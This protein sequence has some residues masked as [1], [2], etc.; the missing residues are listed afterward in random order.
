MGR[1]GNG[2]SRVL[3]EAERRWQQSLFHLP[4]PHLSFPTIYPSTSIHYDISI[5]IIYQPL[6]ILYKTIHPYISITSIYSSPIYPYI[7]THM[8]PPLYIHPYVSTLIYPLLYIHPY[9][10][11]HSYPPIPIPLSLS[12]YPFTLS[13]YLCTVL[14][15]K[16]LFYMWI[17]NLY[18]AISQ[19]GCIIWFIPCNNLH[20]IIFNIPYKV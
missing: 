16:I 10:P 20:T 17:R 14:Q 13:V 15:P 12:I 11:T 1:N 2:P 8:Y 5:H 3:K 7:S 9:I 18:G 19:A 6:S 4:P